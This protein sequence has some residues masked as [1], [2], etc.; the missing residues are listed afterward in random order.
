MQA[1]VQGGVWSAGG[2]GNGSLGTMDASPALDDRGAFSG[3]AG[4]SGAA[5]GVASHASSGGQGWGVGSLSCVL[6]SLFG[7]DG[8]GANSGSPGCTL[9][10]STEAR[11]WS[12][13]VAQQHDLL[14]GRALAVGGCEEVAGSGWLPS[15]LIDAV[16]TTRAASEEDRPLC[17]QSWH[18]CA[19]G[20]PV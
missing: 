18:D 11:G 17:Q 8:N 1:Q 16:D 4:C 15:G 19:L 2:L 6:G 9:T 14:A 10:S 7:A 13:D 5:P 12:G 20:A 3:A